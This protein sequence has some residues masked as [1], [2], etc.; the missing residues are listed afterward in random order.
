MQ[1]Q[2]VN[3]DDT[4]DDELRELSFNYY[5]LSQY[6][7]YT[8]S[9]RVLRKAGKVA[10]ALFYEQQRDSIYKKLPEELRW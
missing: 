8:V 1:I 5:L 3:L 10:A 6:A 4:P 7:D 9:A 2:A